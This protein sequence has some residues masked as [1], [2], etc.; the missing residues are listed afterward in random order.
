MTKQKNNHKKLDR[1]LIRL[2]NVKPTKIDR[3][4]YA[5]LHSNW[6]HLKF[7]CCNE[8]RL[9]SRFFVVNVK[10]IFYRL[11]T[12][13]DTCLIFYGYFCLKWLKRSLDEMNLEFFR[14]Y[15]VRELSVCI[16]T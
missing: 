7:K 1:V 6:S 3:M 2:L 10:P 16:C 9:F 5:T 12:I 11:F 14:G 4:A 13:V 15:A 8:L